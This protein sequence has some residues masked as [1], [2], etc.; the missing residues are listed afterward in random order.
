[1]NIR[2]IISRPSGVQ[3]LAVILPGALRRRFGLGPQQ[4]R[5]A[6]PQ[7]RHGTRAPRAESRTGAATPAAPSPPAR[8]R[9]TLTSLMPWSAVRFQQMMSCARCIC[10]AWVI[11]QSRLRINHDSLRSEDALSD[12]LD[13]PVDALSPDDAGCGKNLPPGVS[14]VA[15]KDGTACCVCQQLLSWRRVSHTTLSQGAAKTALAVIEISFD[16]SGPAS[17]QQAAS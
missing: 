8:M 3:R 13:P 2:G 10:Q 6:A 7:P 16:K 4:Q 12:A 17:Q 9:P 1:M 14:G 11:H 15:M 5:A